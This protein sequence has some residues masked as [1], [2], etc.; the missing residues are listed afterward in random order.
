MANKNWVDL[1]ITQIQKKC[2]TKG[3][4]SVKFSDNFEKCAV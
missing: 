3:T 1:L 4:M 2:T